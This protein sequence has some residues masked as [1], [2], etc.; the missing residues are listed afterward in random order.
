MSTQTETGIETRLFVGGAFVDAEGGGTF[1]NRDP[2]TDEVVS[3]VAAGGREDARRAVE[4]AAA[5]FPEW[6]QTPPA[7]RQ[8][9]L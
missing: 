3:E 8:G 2:F 6:S 1:E 9:V 7:V 5:A 4:A